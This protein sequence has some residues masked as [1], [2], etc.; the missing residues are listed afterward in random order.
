MG[1]L[2]IHTGVGATKLSRFAVRVGDAFHLD[3]FLVLANGGS[4]AVGVSR[5][6]HLATFVTFADPVRLAH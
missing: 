5:A 6:F 2:E 4:D 1:I 3:A